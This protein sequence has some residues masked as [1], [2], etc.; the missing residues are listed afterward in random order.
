MTA[1]EFAHADAS[2]ATFFGVH[3]GL[4]MGSIMVCGSEE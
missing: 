4:G 3:A 1:L 2:I